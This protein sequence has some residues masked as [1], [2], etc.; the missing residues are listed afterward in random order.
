MEEV[1]EE[2]S[3]RAGEQERMERISPIVVQ[4]QRSSTMESGAVG[5]VSSQH[6]RDGVVEHA[7]SMQRIF[8]GSVG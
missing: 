5:A 8:K 6:D 2:E 7:L 3:R 4:P 1:E